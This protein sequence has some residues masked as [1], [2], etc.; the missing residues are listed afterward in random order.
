MRA[1][2]AV[3]QA[4]ADRDVAHCAVFDREPFV[5]EKVQRGLDALAVHYGLRRG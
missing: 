2:E 3:E 5:M 4:G 1:F